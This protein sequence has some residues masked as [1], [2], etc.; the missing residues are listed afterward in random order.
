MGNGKD[1]SSRIDPIF[2][3]KTPILFAHRGGVLEAPESTATAFRYALDVAKADVLELDVQMTRDGRFVVWHG[4]EV[5]KVR[6]ERIY[7]RPAKRERN[8][9]CDYD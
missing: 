9:I 3:L 4:P 1:M 6:I 5:S 8:K 2:K 7:D